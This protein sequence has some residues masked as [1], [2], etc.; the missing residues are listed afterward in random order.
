MVKSTTASRSGMLGATHAVLA[1]D[2]GGTAR[3]MNHRMA[4]LEVVSRALSTFVS[5]IISPAYALSD[6]KTSQMRNS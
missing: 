4:F 6:A 1:L 5:V 3:Q 2:S